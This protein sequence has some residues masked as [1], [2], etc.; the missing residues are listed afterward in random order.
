MDILSLQKRVWAEIDLDCIDFNY[1]TIGF[2]TCCV[3]KANA[4]GHGAVQLA[5]RYEELAAPYLAVS[6][7]EEALQLRRNGISTP[8][9][10][11]GYTSP[12]CAKELYENNIEQCVYSLDYANELSSAAV[13]LGPDVK[14][15]C[16]I[17][18]D[19]GMGRLGFQYHDGKDELGDIIRIRS[20]R[21]LVLFGVFTHFAVADEGENDFTRA[22]YSSFTSAIGT[23]ESQNV[24]FSI[25]HCC[26][27]AAIIDYSEYHLDMV[28]AGLIL[29]GINPTK[30]ESIV[31]KPALSLWS[32][33]SHVK[34][35]EKGDSISYGRSF[36]SKRKTR[37]ATIPIGYAD[38]FWRSNQGRNVYINGEFCRIIGRVCMDQIMVESRTAMFGD[39]VEIYGPHLP[40]KDAAK[41]NHTIP[42]EL[43]CS[44]GERVP[45]VY[46][47]GGEIIEVV[48]KLI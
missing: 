43:M 1:R 28:R 16:H 2:P 13:R 20:L 36:I 27:S 17:K 24:R 32:V 39:L 23:L 38:G 41:E 47:D 9:L 40:I 11:L 4:Y 34:V 18:I 46:K 22:Q 21:G 7:I 14:I 5:R 19:T 6:N 30:N 31:L 10:V 35:V 33:V 25:K 42:Y 44:I 12:F 26:N 3:I 8:I 15:K 37:V 48:D 29:Y 45:R